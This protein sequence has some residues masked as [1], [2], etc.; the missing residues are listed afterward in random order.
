MTAQDNR[1]I[2]VDCEMTGLD[3]ETNHLL[4]IAIIITDS[5]LNIIAEGPNLIIHQPAVLLEAMDEWNT[6]QHKK[7]GL[8]SL[9]LTSAI[10][11][12]DA[13]AILVDFIKAHCQPK[14]S[15]LCGNTVH[16]DRLF[17]KKYTPQLEALFHYRHIDVSTIKELA[18]KWRT[19]LINNFIK[20]DGHRALEDIL[21]SIQELRY[22]KQNFF[23]IS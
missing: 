23:N 16:Q 10:N 19:D 5:Q 14:T 17:L 2:W 12:S 22:Y 1:L 6:L 3:V 20:K 9:S 11:E 8:Y 21:E 7:T 4:E 13:Q 15:P 18:R